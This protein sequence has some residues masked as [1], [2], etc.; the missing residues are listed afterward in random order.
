M[1]GELVLSAR[2][3]ELEEVQEL[4]K[5]GVDVN[6]KDEQGRTALHMVRK[7]RKKEGEKSGEN[8]RGIDTFTSVISKRLRAIQSQSE[9]TLSIYPNIF[10]SAR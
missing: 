2:Y 10:I 9:R 6:E 4:L 5:A 1:E 3:G 8:I 7:R